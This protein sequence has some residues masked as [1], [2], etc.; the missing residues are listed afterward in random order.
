VNPPVVGEA[1]VHKENQ[2]NHG[3]G[4]SQVAQKKFGRDGKIFVKG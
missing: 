4:K 2:H 3:K 1:D